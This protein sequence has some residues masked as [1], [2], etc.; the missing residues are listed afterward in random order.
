LIARFKFN[1]QL[2]PL[3][4]TRRHFQF[5]ASVYSS[6]LL[7]VEPDDCRPQY[8]IED[9]PDLFMGIEIRWPAEG[10]VKSDGADIAK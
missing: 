7:A 9:E 10:A 8:R 3:G 2:V 4:E 1:Y 6:N 5:G